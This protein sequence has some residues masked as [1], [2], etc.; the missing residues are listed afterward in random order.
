MCPININGLSSEKD[1][2]GLCTSCAQSPH[3]LVFHKK[4]VSRLVA[5]LLFMGFIVFV[6]GFFFG[7]KQGAE[8]F[9][10]RI[11]HEN[12]SDQIHFALS[13]LYDK[14]ANGQ[15]Y[16]ESETVA[17]NHDTS[18]NILHEDITSC[19]TENDHG[20]K[21][22]ST[23]NT[24]SVHY[25]AQ[26]FGGKQKAVTDFAQRLSKHGIDI[27]IRERLSKSARGKNITWFQAIT[28]PYADKNELTSIVALIKKLEKINDVTIIPVSS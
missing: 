11:E 27:V 4:M 6:I 19:A 20:K 18:E 5:L 28:K 15:K 9:G 16:H 10:H 24:T 2:L 13:S 3:Y 26:L 22:Q 14:D 8:D 12:F 7:K 23:Q 17:V 25:V 1:E 21:V